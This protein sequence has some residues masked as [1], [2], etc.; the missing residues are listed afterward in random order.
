M[1][2]SRRRVHRRIFAGLAVVLPVLLVAALALRP[3]VPTLPLDAAPLRKAA[4]FASSIP[5]DHSKVR[6][7][8]YGFEASM[9]TTGP[10]APRLLVRPLVPILG[11]DLL[12][13]WT[14]TEVEGASLPND[15][16]LVGHL[17]GSAPRVLLLPQQATRVDGSALVYSLGYQKVVARIPLSPL[18]AESEQ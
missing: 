17:A 9:Q 14:G 7:A 16:V 2:L 13:Y 11:P 18:S 10:D 4:G 5:D 12:V 6:S 8:G 15:A 1:I 3:E